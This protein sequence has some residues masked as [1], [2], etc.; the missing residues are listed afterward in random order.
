MR[1]D[2]DGASRVGGITDR[3]IN[4]AVSVVFES[5]KKEM[6]KGAP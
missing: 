4:A 6:V 3:N 5:T 1:G 2:G